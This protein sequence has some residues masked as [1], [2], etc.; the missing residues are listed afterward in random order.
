MLVLSDKIHINNHTCLH[1]LACP[2]HAGLPDT[3]L[4]WPT[5]ISIL[6]G[7]PLLMLIVAGPPT[8][9]LASDPWM[10]SLSLACHC[11]RCPHLFL[12]V[13]LTHACCSARAC[14]SCL[15]MLFVP[16]STSLHWLLPKLMWSSLCSIVIIVHSWALCTCQ[17]MPTLIPT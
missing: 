14:C 12:L 15:A 13:H 11:Y 9:I 17:Q 3:Q 7:P 16:A 10:C 5:P 4:C 8:L 6:A 2:T 1:L